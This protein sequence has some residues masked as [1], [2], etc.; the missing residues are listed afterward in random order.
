MTTETIHLESRSSF[1]E[2][3]FPIKFSEEAK[4]AYLSHKLAYFTILVHFAAVVTTR[5]VSDNK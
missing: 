2:K 3:F 1:S 4:F 5:L